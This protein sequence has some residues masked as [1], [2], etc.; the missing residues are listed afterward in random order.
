MLTDIGRLDTDT[1]VVLRLPPPVAAVV[2]LGAWRGVAAAG[3]PVQVD[4]GLT[5][6]D[7]N[8]C[9]AAAMR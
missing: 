8:A 6:L 4:P 1:D 7:L 5:L 2:G 3:R 9:K